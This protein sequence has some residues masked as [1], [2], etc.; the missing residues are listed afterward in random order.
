MQW[1]GVQSRE[2]CAGI[3]EHIELT[4]Q[5][6]NDTSDKPT[7]EKTQNDKEFR[8][9]YISDNIGA[10][11]YMRSVARL[12]P[13]K[14][15]EHVMKNE[16]VLDEINRRI[17]QGSYF[18][19]KVWFL[20]FFAE[21]GVPVSRLKLIP[22]SIIFCFRIKN[23]TGLPWEQNFHQ[24][25]SGPPWIGSRN[26]VLNV[27]FSVFYN[28]YYYLLRFSSPSTVIALTHLLHSQYF[29]LL[30]LL[31]DAHLCKTLCGIVN[32]H[33]ERGPGRRR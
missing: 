16:T 4:S 5:E 18:I 1:L 8:R 20:E 25:N 9:Y 3:P 30:S 31:I 13:S 2:N 6:I 17:T 33:M 11:Y 7:L 19:E 29:H 10:V 23:L 24:E 22:W 12:C 28:L 15:Y 21:R 27:R 26:L 32:F 14:K